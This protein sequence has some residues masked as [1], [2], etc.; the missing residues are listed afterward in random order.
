MA[1]RTVSIHEDEDPKVTM[2]EE[3]GKAYFLS[4]T[5]PKTA[6]LAARISGKIN[7]TVIEDGKRR[8]LAWWVVAKPNRQAGDQPKDKVTITIDHA[9]LE[10]IDREAEQAETYR[11]SIIELAIKLYLASE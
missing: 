6:E 5:K 9:L 1:L 4:K 8:R 10:A 3:W 2:E 11:S 7:Q